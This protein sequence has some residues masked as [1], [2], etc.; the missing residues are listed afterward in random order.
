MRGT[1]TVVF[2]NLRDVRTGEEVRMEV[3]NNLAYEGKLLIARFLA[4]QA[5]KETLRRIKNPHEN[6]RNP[7]EGSI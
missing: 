6:I 4:E 1:H 2:S 5:A 7:H 3:P